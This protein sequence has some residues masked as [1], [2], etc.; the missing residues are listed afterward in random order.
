MTAHQVKTDSHLIYAPMSSDCVSSNSLTAFRYSRI[1]LPARQKAYIRNH[2]VRAII[3]AEFNFPSGN[4][5]M[6]ATAVVVKHSQLMICKMNFL[7]AI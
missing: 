1:S 7:R 4:S 3:Q 6:T 5:T 2:N